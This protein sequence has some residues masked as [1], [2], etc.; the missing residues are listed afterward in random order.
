MSND[1]DSE[2]P[3]VYSSKPG[4]STMYAA[5]ERVLAARPDWI[6]A[7][8]ASSFDLLIAERWAIPHTR[9]GRDG[10]GGTPSRVPMT[11]HARGS[12]AI[13]V[14]GLMVKS[15]RALRET[16]R[17]ADVADFLPETFLATPGEAKDSAERAA[18]LD[19]PRTDDD[20]WICKPT[21]GA[22]GVGIEICKDARDALRCVDASHRSS[23]TEEK[24][25]FTTSETPKT[26]EGSRT[27]PAGK[28]GC[29]TRVPL[30]PRQPPAWLVQH[31]I[32]NPMLVDGRKFDIRAFALVTY[33]VRVFW[34]EDWIVRTCSERFDMR[35]V[36]N[37]TAHISNHC[38]Q[39]RS[40]T[41][42]AFEEGNEIFA[43][44]FRNRL[45]RDRGD[46]AGARLH[47][48]VVA[49][50][51]RAVAQTIRCVVDTMGGS[52][53]YDAF[54]VLGYDFMPDE[55]G[56][57]WL[58]EVNG[59]PAAAERMTQTIAED[60]VELAVDA[61]FPPRGGGR[62][63]NGAVASRRWVELNLDQACV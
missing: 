9:L 55:E 1:D 46:N 13:T 36:S 29:E 33:D 30:R 39:A 37:R 38:V 53:A 61:R 41:F 54:Q 44:A 31:Y 3:Y 34:F 51:R 10:F 23:E 40:D 22:H 47:A 48:S 32:S 58:L 35:D 21:G 25:T 6:S 20:C 62:G 17:G 43:A 56:K 27:K 49:Q 60:L 52:D 12:K 19:T 5:V 8:S 11:N 2:E 59:S 42:G 15:L 57:V 18:L 45:C 50:M 63:E 16:V 4:V 14:K 24:Q 28:T 26:R 7:S